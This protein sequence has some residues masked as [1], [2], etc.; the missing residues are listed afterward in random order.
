MYTQATL[1]WSRTLAHLGE[2]PCLEY[3]IPGIVV[4]ER[5]TLLCCWEGR[6]STHDDWAPIRPWLLRSA[7]DGQTWQRTRF[8]LSDD[9]AVTINNPLLIADGRR[10]HLIFHENTAR[11]FHCQ[12][13]DDGLT[14]SEPADITP[15]LRELDYDWNVCAVGPGHGIRLANGTLVAPI[16]VAK[17]EWLDDR[18]RAHHPSR[19]GAIYSTNGGA[20]WHGGQLFD[21]ICDGNETTIAELRDHRLLYNLRNCEPDM[22]RRLALSDDSG[23]TVYG[24]RLA[25]DLPDPWC[26]GGMVSLADGTLLFSNC[27][28][29]G[30]G[31]RQRID[32]AVKQ[33]TDDG[34]TWQKLIDVDAI[35]GY[36]DIAVHGDA[37]YILYEKTVDGAVEEM[38]LNKYLLE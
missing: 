9:T 13:E 37:L 32:L 23:R 17:G 27:T 38:R 4:S 8:T 24:L 26:F 14:W 16:W 7:D 1:A 36:S 2:G 10:V 33:S 19:C 34:A 6:M 30:E 11:A 29:D 15:G 31:T 25:A 3:R 35:G 20:T 5:G 28:T 12:S 22:H 21:G 18:R